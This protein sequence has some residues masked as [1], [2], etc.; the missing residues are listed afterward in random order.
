MLFLDE[1]T[2]V[3]NA[4]GMVL[5]RLASATADILLKAA[6]EDRDDKVVIIN[7]EKAVVTGSKTSVF[8]KYQEKY[9][10]NHARKG[11]F[12]PRMPD[13]ILKRA[14]RGML[15]LPKQEQW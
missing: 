7:A 13:M 1:T 12:F 8:N 3:F 6:R 15:P 2:F 11:P 10:L 5:G 14:V 9:K 4:D